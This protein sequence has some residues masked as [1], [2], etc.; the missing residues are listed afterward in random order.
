M[1][2]I[3]VLVRILLELYIKNKKITIKKISKMLQNN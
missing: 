3:E 1:Q 2:I